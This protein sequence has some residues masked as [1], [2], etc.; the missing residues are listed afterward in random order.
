M[1]RIITIIS[2][3]MLFIGYLKA[4]I[5]LPDLGSPSD[6]YLSKLDEPA[7]GKAYFRN[8][9]QQGQVV[10]DPLLNEY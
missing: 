5:E 3:S 1:K 2:C 8:M 6:V 4:D 10:E 7:I 9:R